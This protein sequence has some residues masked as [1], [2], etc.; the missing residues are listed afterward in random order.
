MKPAVS[1][2]HFMSLTA[3]FDSLEEH[4]HR[5]LTKNDEQ[6]SIIEQNRA[7]TPPLLK[8][9]WVDPPQDPP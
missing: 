7:I 8:L 2:S 3:R 9:F 6:D 5:I 1:L 4:D